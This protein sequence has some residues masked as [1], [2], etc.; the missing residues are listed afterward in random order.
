M[1][2]LHGLDYNLFLPRLSGTSGIVMI[3]GYVF[4]RIQC[5]FVSFMTKCF[6]VQCIA[7]TDDFQPPKQKSYYRVVTRTGTIAPGSGITSHE[8]RIRKFF[9]SFKGSRI[10][11]F[12]YFS[13]LKGKQ[14]I[15]FL[16]RNL[17][18]T[19]ACSRRSDSI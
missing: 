14:K 8:I 19:I 4:I 15:D 1:R 11:H 18:I 17:K 2:R 16:A 9:T 13:G 5:S 10:G 12:D 3:D 6:L 7:S